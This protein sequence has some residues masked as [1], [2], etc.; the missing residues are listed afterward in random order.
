MLNMNTY[1]PAFARFFA[2]AVCSLLLSTGAAR[3][4]G[5]TLA[6]TEAL[7]F[8]AGSLATMDARS[9]ARLL[10]ASKPAGNLVRFNRSWIDAQPVI[11][12]GEEWHCLAQALYFEARGE[13]IKGQ[14]A[15]AEVIL[16]RVAST[17]FPNT[18]C[19]VI[20]QGTGKRYRCQFSYMC[21]GRAEVIREQAAWE[22]VGKVARLS[23]AGAAPK[24]T[25]G[26]KFYHTTAVRPR[27]SQVFEHTTTIG[28]HKFYRKS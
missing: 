1:L 22:R 13:R 12:G 28:V 2:A 7:A 25:N 26:A 4:D 18:I 24:L 19:G 23:M 10:K 11:E 3:A 9:A 6:V 17:E 15:V 8:E 16:N 21:D 14:F 5:H 27:W 20:N